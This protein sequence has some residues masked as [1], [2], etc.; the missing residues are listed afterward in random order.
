MN[1]GIDLTP[2]NIDLDVQKGKGLLNAGG[3]GSHAMV[4]S[5]QIMKI[6]SGLTPQ[7]LRIVPVTIERV[8]QLLG[9]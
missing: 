4:D 5:A 7:I 6:G 2:K 8:G 1:G 9:V 3:A